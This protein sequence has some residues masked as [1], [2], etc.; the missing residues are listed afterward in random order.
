MSVMLELP[1]ELEAELATEAARL[2]LPLPDY[3]LRLLAAG[4]SAQPAPKNGAELVAYWQ[5]AGVVGDRAEIT[6]SQAH[7]RS[8]REN[9]QKRTRQ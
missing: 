4:R 8:L 9:A 6:D 2:N 7:A 5:L 1:T 3:I